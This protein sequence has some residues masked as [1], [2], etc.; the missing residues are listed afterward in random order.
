M[1]TFHLIGDSHT[2]GGWKRIA[3]MA[4]D[5]LIFGPGKKPVRIFSHHLST[6]LAYSFGRDALSRI[7]IESGSWTS[8]NHLK[9]STTHTYDFDI[10]TGDSI[11]FVLGEPDCRCHLHKYV[12]SNNTAEEIISE[13]IQK[14][15]DA[16]KLNVDKLNE[17]LS[18]E[19]GSNGSER[20][21]H[22]NVYIQNVVP[23]FRD[24]GKGFPFPVLGTQ[25]DR[26]QYVRLFNTYCREQST[27]YKYWFI[28][29]YKDYSDS[30]GYF[31]HSKSDT[32][33]VG[34]SGLHIAEHACQPQIN[35]L[36]RA[37]FIL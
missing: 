12:T 15:L 32:T 2:K 27:K 28:N 18:S 14:Y 5:G 36:K 25:E 9:E 31:I 22:V 21:G 8:T 16:I 20:N 37:G 29:L 7:D 23:P 10:K 33:V 19:T 17:K 13:M 3:E 4:R 24:Y 34:G 6:C 30:E 11:C 35:F 26:L 1:K